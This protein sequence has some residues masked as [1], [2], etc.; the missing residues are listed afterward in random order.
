MQLEDSVLLAGNFLSASRQGTRGVC[1]D[2]A[3]RLGAKGWRVVNTSDKPKRLSRMLD[4]T[5]TAWSDRRTYGVAM[6]D[7]YS[8]NAFVL[9]EAICWT[10]RRAGKPY[11]LAL[12]GGDLPSFA[13]RWPG[14]MRR[15]HA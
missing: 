14:R 1:E 11:A 3:T 8:G 10:L 4:M 5:T 13:K 2:L 15:L 7:V 6:V 12:R 9:A